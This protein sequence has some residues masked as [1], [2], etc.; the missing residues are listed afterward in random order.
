V[1]SQLETDHKENLYIG[2]RI[3][4]KWNWGKD[5]IYLAQDRDQ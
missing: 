1:G 5:W 4:L 3:I 2:E